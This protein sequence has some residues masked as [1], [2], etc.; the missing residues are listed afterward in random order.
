MSTPD[1]TPT[2]LL[3]VFLDLTRF[4]GEGARIGDAGTATMIDAYYHRVADAVQSAGG[5]VVK[6]IGD[7]TLAVFGEESVDRAVQMLLDLKPAVDAYM[8]ENGWE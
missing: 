6:F 4:A 2:R 3:I 1:R 5:T 7:A 8:Q